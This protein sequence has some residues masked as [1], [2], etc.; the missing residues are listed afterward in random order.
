MTVWDYNPIRSYW[1]YD[2]SSK[3]RRFAHALID[4]A[5]VD[6]LHGHSS[7]HVKAVE[8]Y[9]DKLILYGCGDFLNDYEGISGY[10]E[11]RADLSLMYFATVN[12]AN[13]K[14]IRMQMTPTRIRRFKINRAAGADAAWL[15][16]MLNR[17][18]T[19]SGTR[20]KMDRDNRLVLHWK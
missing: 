4:D 15:M 20:V 8:I 18:G 5:G 12:S 1:G 9:K 19:T 6:I 16:D 10:E 13:G 7:H 2:I 3:Q 17:E 11:F 14:L